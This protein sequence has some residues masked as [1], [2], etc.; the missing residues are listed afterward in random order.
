MHETYAHVRLE[1]LR[2]VL[3]R[4]LRGLVTQLFGLV[5][6]GTH[7]VR[8]AAFEHLLVDA[9]DDLVA[10]LC[11]LFVIAVWRFAWPA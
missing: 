3:R 8:L 11:T 6:E 5:D 10:A 7:P 2:K 9:F 1:C 4:F